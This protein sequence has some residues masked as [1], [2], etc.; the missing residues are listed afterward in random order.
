MIHVRRRTTMDEDS[1][2]IRDYLAAPPDL[3]DNL[4]FISITFA[5]TPAQPRGGA[6]CVSA[7]GLPPVE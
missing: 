1:G 5:C 7:L 4:C 6:G 2:R 3:A